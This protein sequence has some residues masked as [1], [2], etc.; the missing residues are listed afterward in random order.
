MN[1][2]LLDALLKMSVHTK[3]R[4]DIVTK[5]RCI[6]FKTVEIS[7]HFSVT[8]SCNMVVKKEDRGH[9]QFHSR[10]VCTDL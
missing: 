7:H 2:S 3:F 6:D 10:L 5:K 4:K 8:M 1:I 9:L